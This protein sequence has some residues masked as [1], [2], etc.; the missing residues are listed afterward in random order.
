MKHQL[1]IIDN[2]SDQV[3]EVMEFDTLKEAQIAYEDSVDADL[4][5]GEYERYSYE[6]D[7]QP[8]GATYEDSE[9]EAA[10]LEKEVEEA[11]LAELLNEE[12]PTREQRLRDLEE[13]FGTPEHTLEETWRR[14]GL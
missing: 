11:N 3:T 8:A 14:W 13:A 4:E 2:E 12:W 1:T 9:A 10:M 7:G 6:I 5:N